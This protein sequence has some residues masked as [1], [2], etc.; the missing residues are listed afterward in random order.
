MPEEAAPAQG[1]AGPAWLLALLALALVAICV[2]LVLLRRK[3][4]EG[5]E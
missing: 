2:A 4:R 5:G 1:Q 3:R